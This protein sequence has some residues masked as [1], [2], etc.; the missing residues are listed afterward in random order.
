MVSAEVLGRTGFGAI[1]GMMA[2]PFLLA[3]ALSP[4]LGSILERMGGYDLALL[5]ALGAS[6]LA[7][8][9]LALLTILLKGKASKAE[10]S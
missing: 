5:F 8:A 10:R 6:S 4:Q 2:V 1:S 3:L 7:L 9:A